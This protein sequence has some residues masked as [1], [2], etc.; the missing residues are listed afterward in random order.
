[1]IKQTDKMTFKVSYKKDDGKM[2]SQTFETFA[3]AAGHAG[4]LNNVTRL[5]DVEFSDGQG[6][7]LSGSL[8]I[9]SAKDNTRRKAN[10]YLINQVML[11][12]EV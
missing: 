10:Q 6:F 7:S 8:Y 9:Y 12:S 3:S 5:L 4:A 11:R 2:V 1:M